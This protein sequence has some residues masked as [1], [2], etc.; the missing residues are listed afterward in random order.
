MVSSTLKFNARLT[1]ITLSSRE[2]LWL[3]NSIA[4]QPPFNLDRWIFLVPMSLFL[5]SLPIGINMLLFGTMKNLLASLRLG[6]STTDG[7][8]R[9]AVTA[10]KSTYFPIIGNGK[11]S[12]ED[13]GQNT[14]MREATSTSMWYIRSHPVSRMMLPHMSFLY[15]KNEKI[16]SPA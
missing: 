2:R 9:T 8:T 10:D 13:F 12:S 5:T 15:N 7:R 1:W 6:S 3:F 14:L 11:T 16:G 4:M